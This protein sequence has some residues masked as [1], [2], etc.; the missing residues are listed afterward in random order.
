MGSLVTLADGLHRVDAPIG[1]RFASL[2]VV[3]GNTSALLFDTGVDGTIPSHVVPALAEI[4]VDARDVRT[5]VVSHCDVDHFG[6][7]ADAR[8]AF[9]RAAIRA[10]ALDR[11]AIEDYETYLAERA[12]GFRAVYGL[13]EDEDVLAWCRSV[14][15]ESP[16]DADVV[17]DESIDLGGRDVVIWHL[18]G[19]SLG[20]VGVDVPW[21]DAVMISDA[22]LGASVNLADGSPAFPPTYRFVD[23]YLSTLERLESAGR[24]SLLT[25]HYPALTGTA[26]RDFLA[27]SRAFVARLDHLV[28]SELSGESRTLAELI[29]ILNPIA[30]DWPESGT[31]KALAFPVV[32]HLE[33]LVLSGAA[34]RSG[35]RNGVATW[36]MS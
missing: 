34:S 35:E 36:S 14:T 25:A 28:V 22:A 8:E 10:H 24:E 26:S 30:G 33:R 19:H 27:E 6:G 31:A 32:G 20:S 17:D 29:E 12:R 4:G 11:D 21:A 9:P 23:E 1:E 7:V 5:V 15:R 16:L 2:Y 18:P 13:D 3:V